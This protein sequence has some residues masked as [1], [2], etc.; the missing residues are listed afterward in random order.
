MEI[1]FNFYYYNQAE[2]ELKEKIEVISGGKDTHYYQNSLDHF[3]DMRQ[4]IIEFEEEVNSKLED[5]NFD[6]NTV[7][8]AELDEAD[9]IRES[10]EI[11]VN[12]LE[13]ELEELKEKLENT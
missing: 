11:Q 12:D 9:V 13:N 4:E 2:S 8:E 6:K 7:L 5:Y 3:H 1:K 10:L